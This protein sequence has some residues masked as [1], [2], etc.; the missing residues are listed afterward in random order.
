MT[1]M[2]FSPE[3]FKLIYSNINN[4]IER[5]YG[6]SIPKNN[7]YSG[8]IL[9][10]MKT[11]YASKNKLNISQNLSNDD[12]LNLLTKK[13]IQ[14]FMIYFEK[15]INSSETIF[16]ITQKEMSEVDIGKNN[17]VSYGINNTNGNQPLKFNILDQHIE[18]EYSLNK[19]SNTITGINEMD[20]RTNSTTTNISQHN[21]D[22]QKK[23]TPGTINQTLKQILLE[24]QSKL[25]TLENNLKTKDSSMDNVDISQLFHAL[26]DG[27]NFKV[28]SINLVIDTGD[29]PKGCSGER[30]SPFDVKVS[31]GTSVPKKS[32]GV[33][34]SSGYNSSNPLCSNLYVNDEIK[35]VHSIRLDRI[36]IPEV[37]LSG[38][39][40]P[41][42]YL[43]IEE[44]ESNVI[45]T[46]YIKN[47]FAKMYID[48]NTRHCAGC[49][50]NCSGF[51]HYVNQENDIKIFKTPLST[52]SK[53][54]IKLINPVG[55]NLCNNWT[56]NT[57]NCSGGDDNY[58]DSYVQYMFQ[59]NTLENYIPEVNL[60]PFN[61]N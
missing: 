42:L 49:S 12:T 30:V 7:F 22:E 16:P 25:V 60:S 13:S 2:F 53:M 55:K 39:R 8:K 61:N 58:L 38:A 29:A 56:F 52:L 33:V 18:T 35:N 6:F 44:F 47:I 54:S 10:I 1:S 3:N 4:N 27:S 40:Y 51:L 23:T 11:I 17:I 57:Y 45:T 46:G 5:K 36:V 26:K 31:F 21:N 9:E 59:I 14:Y 37:H 24:N 28:N 34:F 41:F 48:S 50:T 32:N 15:N 43:C 19:P 20:Y